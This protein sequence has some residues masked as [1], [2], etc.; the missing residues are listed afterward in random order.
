[1]SDPKKFFPTKNLDYIQAR[2]I[3]VNSLEYVWDVLE[4]KIDFELKILKHT[5]DSEKYERIKG[6][7]KTT[8]YRNIVKVIIDTKDLEFE[9]I[10]DLKIEEESL[11]SR[12]ISQVK[13]LPNKLLNTFLEDLHYDPQINDNTNLKLFNCLN[14]DLRSMSNT[15][16]S[17]G[18]EVIDYSILGRNHNFNWYAD[19]LFD[20]NQVY[21][22]I[23]GAFIPLRNEGQ[24]ADDTSDIDHFDFLTGSRIPA[25]TIVMSN[26]ATLLIYFCL[27]ILGTWIKTFSIIGVLDKEKIKQISEE[28]DD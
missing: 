11:Y 12:F 23:P 13:I 20:L 18:I 5:L 17:D 27:E 14:L 10:A 19:H 25:N 15:I 8:L 4:V 2:K 21:W 22:T 28:Q 16:K 7:L 9:S 3:S 24:H 26:I 1:M 6:L